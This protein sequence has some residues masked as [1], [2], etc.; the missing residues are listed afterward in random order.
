[1]WGPLCSLQEERGCDPDCTWHRTSNAPNPA[2]TTPDRACA[3]WLV[4]G[5]LPS[6]RPGTQTH[7]IRACGPGEARMNV[8]G[9][10]A[11]L[12]RSRERSG[13]RCS[14]KPPLKPSSQSRG[15]QPPHVLPPR[16]S[17][18][19][20]SLRGRGHGSRQGQQRPCRAGAPRGLT[21]ARISQLPRWPKAITSVFSTPAGQVTSRGRHAGKT[22][23]CIRG[24]SA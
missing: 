17:L 4:G 7:Q 22:V 8:V 18:R 3:S 13:P 1:M 19:P 14:L 12:K 23:Q 15:H 9:P 24:P 21:G 10:Q 6:R 20:R 2:T 5:A 16:T 11:F